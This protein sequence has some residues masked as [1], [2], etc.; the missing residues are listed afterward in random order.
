MRTVLAAL[1][2]IP[3]L[4]PAVL[5]APPAEAERSGRF[6]MQPVE[7]GVLRMD[8]ETGAMSL[9]V[10]RAAGLT[11]EPVEDKAG[12]QR[13][14]DR[15]ATENRELKAEIRR[16]EDM[17]GLGDKPVE[18]PVRKFE[19]PSE[20]DVDKA[21]SYVERMIRKFREKLK[22]LEGATGSGKGTQL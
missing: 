15:L 7:G 2:V 1:L 18:K 12:G 3:A 6:V 11:C 21:M 16:L 20:Q 13:D 4:A 5:A 17:L 9:C 19:L 10:K 22:D 8:S 14:A